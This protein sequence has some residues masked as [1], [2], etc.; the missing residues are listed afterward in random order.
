MKKYSLYVFDLDGVLYRG[1][2]VV[3]GTPQAVDQIKARGAMVRYLTNNS[4]KTR[5]Q[6]AGKLVGMGFPANAGDVYSSASA[7]GRYLEDRHVSAAYVLGEPGLIEELALCGVRRENSGEAG[8]VVVGVCRDLTYAL[9]D[10]A[11]QRVRAGAGFLA[12]NPDLT[13]PDAGGV[14]RPGAGSIVAAVAAASGRRPDIVVGKPQTTLMEM[15]WADTGIDPDETLLV[16][17]QPDTDILCANRAGCDS[18][19]VLTG[20]ATQAV[21]GAPQPTYVLTS[22]AEIT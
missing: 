2:E 9:L 21:Q 6:Y 13:Y 3:D 19:L 1:D 14:L 11:Q 22:A 4:S 10:E 17:D 5:E 18:A 7:A 16:G 8:W 12:T 15:I 20:V